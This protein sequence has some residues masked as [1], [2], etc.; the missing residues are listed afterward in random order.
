MNYLLKLLEKK[1][2]HLLYKFKMTIQKI[3]KPK[4]D[5][6]FLAQ[7]SEI[8]F[9]AG[10]NYSVVKKR[11]PSMKKAFLNFN[12][13]KLSKFN[14]KNVDKLMKAQGMIKN[15]GKIEAI[16]ENASM[17]L[18]LRKDHGSVLE[19]IEKS[20]KNYKKDPLFNPTLEESFT[21]FKRI[22]KT[23]SGWLASLH[24]AKGRYITYDNG[25]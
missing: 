24:N 16:I 21:R 9:I 5:N 3:Y 14:E 23:T 10:F 12:I 2:K 18:R 15:R 25:K 1:L 20:K 6:E 11:W 4:N 19:W 17:C 7:V 22:G 8:I 13:I